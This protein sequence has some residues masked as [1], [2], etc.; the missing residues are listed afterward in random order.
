AYNAAYIDENSLWREGMIGAYPQGNNEIA[1]S[2]YLAEAI[3]EN[4]LIDPETELPYVLNKTDDLIGKKITTWA[5]SYTSGG[6]YVDYGD[7]DEYDKYQNNSYTI[8]GIF[9]ASFDKKYDA[10]KDSYSAERY[11]DE[12]WELWNDLMQQYQYSPASTLL[13]SKEYFD[14]LL[15]PAT[16]DPDYGY[17][18]ERKTSKYKVTE[19][20]VYNGVIIP[21]NG[22]VALTEQILDL[23]YTVNEDDSLVQLKNEIAETLDYVEY[24]IDDFSGIFLGAGIT[25]AVFSAL[26]FSN[27]ISASIANKRKD[28]GILRAIGARG[29]DVF[30]I[31]FME[32]LFISA[33][34]I[35]LSIIGGVGMCALLNSSFSGAG[36]SLTILV[37]GFP[38]VL[39]VIGVALA[40]AFVATLLPVYFAARK[41]PAE[42]IRA[43]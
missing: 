26:L 7:Y 18:W 27:F 6:V 23:V 17:S 4:S 10:L 40:T 42:T 16:S 11:N 41:K 5:L 15:T 39:V 30:K 32:S 12:N 13:L 22:S 21:Y 28:I 25:F 34:C 20:N 9:L 19:N 36:M 38:S 1:I 3:L 31:F 8:T 2:S 43:L 37:F 14:T 33:I 24:F 29:V 35:V